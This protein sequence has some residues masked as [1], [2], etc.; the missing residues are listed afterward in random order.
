ME[1]NSEILQR[2]LI[3]LF[4]SFEKIE[5]LWLYIEVWC[6]KTDYFNKYL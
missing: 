2:Y 6:E 1:K 4:S 5:R 3:N